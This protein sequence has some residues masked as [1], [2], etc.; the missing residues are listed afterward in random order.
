VEDSVLKKLEAFL[1]SV[2][3]RLTA[4][5]WLTDD[6]MQV[7][8]RK[9]RRLIDGKMRTTLDIA[10]VEVYDKGQGTF[11]DFLN[12]AHDMHPWDAT[13]VECVHNPDLAVFLVRY[14]F[15]PHPQSP[16]SFY[17]PK[18]PSKWYEGFRPVQHRMY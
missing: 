12:K 8:V 11:T 4:N 18:D 15:M 14:G 17:L 10:N 16:S 5:E 2:E 1:A 9:G 6:K 3:T 7:Y 13:Y